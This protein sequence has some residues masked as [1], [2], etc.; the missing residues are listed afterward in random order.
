MSKSG[1][2]ADHCLRVK[3]CFLLYFSRSFLCG[4]Q[5]PIELHSLNIICLGARKA[6]GGEIVKKKKHSEDQSLTL[7]PVL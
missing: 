4:P 6:V 7:E 1:N 2:A 5:I 3:K